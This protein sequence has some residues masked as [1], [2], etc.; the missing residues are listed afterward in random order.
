MQLRSDIVVENLCKHYKGNIH[1]S[2]SGLSLH[3]AEGE[4]FGLLGPNGAGKTT[5]ISI[6]CGLRSFNSGSVSVCG[7]SVPHDLMEI[8]K[9]IGVIP[10]EIALYPTL[11]AYE[12]L[13]VVGGIYAIPKKELRDTIDRLLHRFGLHK[14]KHRR[15]SSYSGGMKRR[16]NLI[17]GI[18]HNPSILILDE[19]TV[20]IDVQSKRVILESLLEFNANGTTIVYSSHYM[21][22]AEELCTTVAFV[23]EGKVIY[24]GKPSELV[25]KLGVG[26]LEGAYLQLTGKTLR[27]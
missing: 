24:Q 21:E 10:Q 2:L 26:N 19:P 27:D 4:I 20:G 22:E 9:H 13:M 11:T 5:T 18:L 8:K 7:L 16:I 23:D 25:A 17:A 12:N 15:I 14:H 1:P 3:I 6:I